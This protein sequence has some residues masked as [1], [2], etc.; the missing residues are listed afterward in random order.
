M[1][2]LS[3][4]ITL[5]VVFLVFLL[6]IFFVYPA[7]KKRYFTKPAFSTKENRLGTNSLD[8]QK[9]EQN[10][11]NSSGEEKNN[12]GNFENSDLKISVNSADC[13]NEC[14]KFKKDE[15]L[16]YCENVCGI[17][18]LY[19]YSDDSG[20]EEFSNCDKKQGV[21]KDYCLKDQAISEKDFKICDQ[22]KDENIKKTCKNRI[23][24]DFLEEQEN[25]ND[26]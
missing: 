25:T 10:K 19:D 5:L 21:Q 26:L 18:D 17:S 14:E 24:E 2:N 20:E 22:V 23:T 3:K 9:D 8:A 12:D 4:K 1:K 13:D 16:K 6:M 15:E 11:N 7:I